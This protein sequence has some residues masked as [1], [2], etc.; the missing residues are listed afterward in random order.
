MKTLIIICFGIIVLIAYNSC[1]SNQGSE[2]RTSDIIGA[3]AYTGNLEGIALYD[4]SHFSFTFR[5][6]M[7][8][9]D[10]VLTC[11][12]RYNSLQAN[13]GT[14]TIKDS[15]VTLTCTFHKD[16]RMI[17]TVHRFVYKNIGNEHHYRLIDQEGKTISQGTA[18]KIK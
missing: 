14:W 5:T 11:E 15:I 16:P 12:E 9:P 2:K 18:I 7:N 1:Q 10:S 17:G 4:E 3:Y 6:K 8:K 13:A